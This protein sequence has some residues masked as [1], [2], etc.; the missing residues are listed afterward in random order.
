MGSVPGLITNVLRFTLGWGSLL[1]SSS[2][3]N[4]GAGPGA[5]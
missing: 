5:L 2:L 3:G 1:M 4:W